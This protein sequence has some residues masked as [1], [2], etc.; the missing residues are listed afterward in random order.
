MC[1]VSY[2]PLSVCT[3][4]FI[5]LNYKIYSLSKFLFSWGEC[6]DPATHV[7]ARLYKFS[8]YTMFTNVVDVEDHLNSL[9][10]HVIYYAAQFR[11]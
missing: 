10:I 9:I 6:E 3:V 8:M 5:C 7:D 11:L 2:K 4:E 1:E